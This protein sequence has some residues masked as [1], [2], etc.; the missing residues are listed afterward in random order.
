MYPMFRGQLQHLHFHE[1]IFPTIL[2]KS[3]QVQAE[4]ISSFPVIGYLGEEA[5][6]HLPTTSCQVAVDSNKLSPEPPLLNNATSLC[7]ITLYFCTVESKS[8][9]ILA[10]ST[11]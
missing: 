5:N 3:P 2:F 6:I 8:E 10:T 7:T 1:E 11:L 4:V 9:W